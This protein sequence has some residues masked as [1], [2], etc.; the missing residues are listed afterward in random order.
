MR[1]IL[2]GHEQLHTSKSPLSVSLQSSLGWGHLG[3]KHIC[4]DLHGE[5][6]GLQVRIEL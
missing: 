3:P 2:D 6:S 1:F 4:F 5:R